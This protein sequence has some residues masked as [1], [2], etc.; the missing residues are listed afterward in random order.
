MTIASGLRPMAKYGK[1]LKTKLKWKNIVQSYS[2]DIEQEYNPKK[3]SSV[4]SKVCEDIDLVKL[5]NIYVFYEYVVFYSSYGKTAKS[6]KC[7]F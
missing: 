2:A 5:I 3:R 6:R 4:A 1:Y 7:L